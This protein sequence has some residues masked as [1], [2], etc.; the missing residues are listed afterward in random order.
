MQIIDTN[1]EVLYHQ[2]GLGAF[3]GAFIVYDYEQAKIEEIIEWLSL[4]CTDNF[5]VSER[6]DFIVAGGCMDNK[7]AFLRGDFNLKTGFRKTEGPIIEY[8]IRLM[9]EDVF[10]FRLRWLDEN[11]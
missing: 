9:Q 7:H 1:I 10:Q 8:E 3:D 2:Q 6:Q 5:V 4:S 11:I